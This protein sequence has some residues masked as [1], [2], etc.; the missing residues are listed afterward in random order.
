MCKHI[1]CEPCVDDVNGIRRCPIC[2]GENEELKKKSAEFA[3]KKHDYKTFFK[4]LDSASVQRS[5]RSKGLNTELD[6]IGNFYGKDLFSNI[7]KPFND[8]PNF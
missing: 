5:T 1:F 8:D 4:K 2:S 3:C 6:I 7:N